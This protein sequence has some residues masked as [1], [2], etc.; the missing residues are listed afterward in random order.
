MD[1]STLRRR[2]ESLLIELAEAEQARHDGSGKFAGISSIYSRHT[3]LASSEAMACTREASTAKG[4][5][6][7][8]RRARMLWE[9]VASLMEGAITEPIEAE[10]YVGETRTSVRLDAEALPFR[11]GLAR[12][13]NEPDRALRSQLSRALEHAIGS[14]DERLSRRVSACQELADGLGFPS[15]LALFSAVSGIDVAAL[16]AE[17]ETV[18]SST[19]DAYR[20]LL[21]YALRKVNNPVELRPRGE[22][23]AHDLTRFARLPILDNLFSSRRLLPSLQRLLEG[24]ALDPDADGRIELD[25]ENRAG[26]A[27]EPYVATLDV[28][29]EIVVSLRPLGGA[30]DYLRLYGAVGIAQSLASIAGDAPFE[31]RWLGDSSVTEGYGAW[32][33]HLLLDAG[34]L[35]RALDADVRAA[36]EAARLVAVERFY[37][38]RRL[39]GRLIYEQTL[40][41][42]G[43]RSELR[44]FF[45]ETMQ[46]ACL[47][48]W[49]TE[50]WLWDVE[51]RL[52][53]ARQLRGIALE[54]VL[55]RA[56]LEEADEDH[57]RNPRTGP[58]LERLWARGRRD[59]AA[60][61]AREL[62]GSLS[63][64]SAAARLIDIAAR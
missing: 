21:E 29:D 12:V 27:L 54:Q 3:E 9:M 17:A 15:Y 59:D 60:A 55:H 6:E 42:E 4:D 20:D 41:R 2:G 56:L 53:V 48:E 38:L 22:A 47:V 62:G 5:E 23:A 31:D 49:S 26:K 19:E 30:G 52:R 14:L 63:L 50:P 58:F 64:E 32:F 43:P 28:P 37:R 18:L 34:Y 8:S 13:P 36:L 45:R 35:Q 10:R 61:L 44:G 57:W 24:M 16:V 33:E 25:L 11:T 46:K 39:C 1:L 40:Y 7:A 51:P